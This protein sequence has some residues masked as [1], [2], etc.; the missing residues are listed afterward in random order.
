MKQ[1]NKLE[2]CVTASLRSSGDIK[3]VHELLLILTLQVSPGYRPNPMDSR[4]DH[5]IIDLPIQIQ[6]KS[7]KV[8]FS[9]IF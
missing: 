8:D 5:L 4:V 6:R 7:A 9:Q 3:Q 1:I 2:F